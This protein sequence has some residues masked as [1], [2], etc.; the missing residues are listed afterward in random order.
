M[1]KETGRRAFSI[2][3]LVVV[4]GVIMVLLGIF[5]PTL[6]GAKASAKQIQQVSNIR[7]VGTLIDLY[8]NDWKESYPIADIRPDWFPDS[9]SQADAERLG[10]GKRWETALIGASL[11]TPHEIDTIYYNSHAFNSVTMYTSPDVMTP[12]TIPVWESH[13]NSAVKQS[14][15]KYPSLKGLV[16]VS[17]VPDGGNEDRL[18]AGHK[19]WNNGLPD[20]P[21]APVL[22]ADSSVSRLRYSELR[23]PDPAPIGY[24]GLG[25]MYTWNGIKGRDR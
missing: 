25:I 11:A 16:G 2:I 17:F 19:L 9:V 10:I 23:K 14:W 6:S 20:G 8:L 18:V 13:Q 22:F 21:L 7:Q 12:T 5:L 1:T 4:I 3:E 24:W 15:A